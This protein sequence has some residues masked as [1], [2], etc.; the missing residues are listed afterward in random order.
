MS[1]CGVIAGE[2]GEG[3]GEE[4]GDGR[5]GAFVVSSSTDGVLKVW[6]L[7]FFQVCNI[8]FISF[9]SSLTSSLFSFICQC[10]QTVTGH[11]GELWDFKINKKQTKL[12][13]CSQLGKV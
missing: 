4:G 6:S 5:K 11:R 8:H 12:Y 2:V 13:T 3:K 7:E 9:F 10:V 1:C